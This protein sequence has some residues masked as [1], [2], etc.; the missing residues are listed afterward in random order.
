MTFIYLMFVLKIPIIALLWIVWWAIHQTDEPE[1]VDQDDGGTKT[2]HPRDP[3][4][5]APRRGPHREPAPPSPPRVRTAR[6]RGR[7]S[8]D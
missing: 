2:P 4:P 3:L 8:Q 7:V 5:H 1:P 6:G